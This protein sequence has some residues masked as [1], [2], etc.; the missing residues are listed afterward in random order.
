MGDGI[1]SAFLK[2]TVFK[3]TSKSNSWLLF[4]VGGGL[5]I[6]ALLLIL[7][8]EVGMQRSETLTPASTR[9]FGASA[10]NT[11]TMPLIGN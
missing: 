2:F 5:S 4:S 8:T 6:V 3:M 7:G 9:R 1:I 11:D 10:I